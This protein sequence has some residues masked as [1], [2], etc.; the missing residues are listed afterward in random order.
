MNLTI[1]I[2]TSNENVKKFFFHNFNNTCQPSLFSF[3]L[4]TAVLPAMLSSGCI[5]PKGQGLG[6][7]LKTA[8]LDK[9]ITKKRKH[10]I[11]CHSLPR[12]IGV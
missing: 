9:F 5:T 12:G 2:K 6:Q 4:S 11:Q 1:L 3:S 7:S 8:A 10:Y